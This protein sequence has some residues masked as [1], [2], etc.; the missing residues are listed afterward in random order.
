MN[1][2]L[3]AGVI[4]L[5]VWWGRRRDFIRLARTRSSRPNDALDV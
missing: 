3:V 4:A 2:L 5:V 1:V